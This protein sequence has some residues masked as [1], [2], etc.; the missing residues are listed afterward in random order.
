MA[1]APG[2]HICVPKDRGK[3]LDD[4]QKELEMIDILIVLACAA[5][6]ALFLFFVKGDRDGDL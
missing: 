4:N 1:N 5:A 6:T 2:H 3:I